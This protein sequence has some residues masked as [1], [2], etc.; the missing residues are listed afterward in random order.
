MHFAFKKFESI[1]NWLINK[2][3]LP[4]Y[5]KRILRSRGIWIGYGVH[6][7]HKYHQVYFLMK[8]MKEFVR[9]VRSKSILIYEWNKEIALILNS[10]LF[11][12]SIKNKRGDYK[13]ISACHKLNKDA[14]Y[15]L[16]WVYCIFLF[17]SHNLYSIKIWLLMWTLINLLVVHQSSLTCIQINIFSH[18][19]LKT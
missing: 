19:P 12:E 8:G 9:M 1:R 7:I 6:F 2:I 16:L 5:G 4:W 13:S 3:S 11:L 18:L 17:S 15:Q 10:I 14:E